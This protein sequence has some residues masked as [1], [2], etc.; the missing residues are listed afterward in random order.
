MLWMKLLHLLL[1]VYWLGADVGTYYA[2]RFVA[3][4][5]LTTAAR[6]TA[7]KIMLGVDLAPRVCMPLTLAS[8]V[9]LAVMGGTL[10]LPASALWGCWLLC[11]LWLLVALWLHHQ[12]G[13]PSAAQVAS[14]DFVFRACMVL[15]LGAAAL[16]M[17]WGPHT[18]VPAWLALKLLCFATTVVCGL[19]IRLQLKP[20]GPAFAALMRDGG[21]APVNL[22]ISSAINR[23]KPFVWMIWALLLV[24]AALGLHALTP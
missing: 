2:S 14:W 23:C 9:Q 11:G 10:S 21:S 7:A 8:G 20:F 6:A 19:A 17:L 12:G 13:H 1:W 24:C 22:Q 16:W 5:Q 18:T 15:L 4:G 3:D